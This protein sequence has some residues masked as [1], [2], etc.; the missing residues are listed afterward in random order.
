MSS[1]AGLDAE[2]ASNQQYTTSTAAG[3]K[4]AHLCI[5]ANIERQ[6]SSSSEDGDETATVEGGV[7][8][9]ASPRRLP[10]I[11]HSPLR[12]SPHRTQQPKRTKGDDCAGL[13]LGN[14]VE[15][16]VI[17]NP[18]IIEHNF[19]MRE[20]QKEIGFDVTFKKEDGTIDH[21]LLELQ[22]IRIPDG[23]NR[24]PRRESQRTTT[25]PLG[26]QHRTPRA[27]ATQTTMLHGHNQHRTPSAAAAQQTTANQHMTPSAAVAASA[28]L[29]HH[30]SATRTP[31]TNQV[32]AATAARMRVQQS[33]PRITPVADALT[34]AQL[35]ETREGFKLKDQR[36]CNL[37]KYRTLNTVPASCI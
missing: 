36:F 7:A 18:D 6:D 27:A 13:S 21:E 12:I 16:N 15:D 4:Q 31:A 9:V 37:S 5:F 14:S 17:G 19:T 30:D 23:E 25:M 2:E 8:T 11:K 29:S 24:T 33:S 10:N 1:Y 22:D 35:N 28:S 26:N 34:D 3:E 32:D 20:C